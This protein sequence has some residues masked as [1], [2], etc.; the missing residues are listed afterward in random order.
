MS[1][2]S[3]MDNYIVVNLYY[4]ILHGNDNEW[5]I[6]IPQ[7]GGIL[8][9][10]KFI[11]RVKRIFLYNSICL[12]FKNLSMVIEVRIMAN[13]GKEEVYWYRSPGGEEQCF[14][15]P[16]KSYYLNW[17]MVTWVGIFCQNSLCCPCDSLYVYF[18]QM[19]YLKIHKFPE[20]NEPFRFIYWQW[21]WED[22]FWAGDP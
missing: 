11:N 16:M 15:V 3:I 21:Q 22:S 18:N 13:S 4:G 7:H 6:I 19:V 12:K 9:S 8:E 17:V 14:R 1:V 2:N 20:N 5:V 10:R